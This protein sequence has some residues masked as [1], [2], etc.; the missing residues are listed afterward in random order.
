MDSEGSGNSDVP[1]IIPGDPKHIQKTLLKDPKVQE[2]IQNQVAENRDA[3][4]AND[5]S[6]IVLNTFQSHSGENRAFLTNYPVTFGQEQIFR[7]ELHV[8]EG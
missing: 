1:V 5:A 4:Q 2:F 3:V 7:H 6:A 8:L